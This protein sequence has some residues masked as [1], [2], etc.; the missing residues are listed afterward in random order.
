L[1]IPRDLRKAFKDPR[2]LEGVHQLHRLEREN[3]ILKRTN[4]ALRRKTDTQKL[5]EQLE[6]CEVELANTKAELELKSKELELVRIKLRRSTEGMN[7]EELH[8]VECEAI[9]AS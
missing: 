2:V 8:F 9:L 6:A 5:S 4:S 1:E 3:M 7:A